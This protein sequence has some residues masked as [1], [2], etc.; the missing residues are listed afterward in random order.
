MIKFD[1]YLVNEM[2][3]ALKDA[4]LMGDEGKFVQE[5]KQAYFKTKGS[6]ENPGA[7]SYHF[8]GASNVQIH[9]GG[10]EG[11]KTWPY[12]TFDVDSGDGQ[13]KKVEISVPDEADITQITDFNFVVDGEQKGFAT[14]TS[15]DQKRTGDITAGASYMLSGAKQAIFGGLRKKAA[16]ERRVKAI[17]DMTD[18]ELQAIIAARAAAKAQAS[19]E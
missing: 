9:D 7:A 10:E 6:L 5:L 1:Q 17:E 3:K 4:A 19:G 12:L 2:P 8:Q 14:T 11:G 13:V 18:E 16:A 15:K